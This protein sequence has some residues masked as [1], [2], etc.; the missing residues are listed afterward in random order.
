MPQRF[1]SRR[2][3]A[4]VIRNGRRI[5]LRL[6]RV[7]A[8]PASGPVGRV[9][10]VVP[11]T[12]SKKST[13]RNR[14]RRILVAWARERSITRLIRQDLV[15]FVN[16]ALGASA[17]GVIRAAAEAMAGELARFGRATLPRGRRGRS[18]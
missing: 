7:S 8:L 9:L 2:E 11:K 16:P 17:P 18:D 12:V 13:V 5:I 1:A 6:G 4:R 3:I 14:I 10:F 15:V